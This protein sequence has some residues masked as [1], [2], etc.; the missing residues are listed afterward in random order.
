[1]IIEFLIVLLIG[2]VAGTF[3]GL[4]PGIHVNLIAVF[5]LSMSSVFLEYVS[6][7]ALVVFITAMAITHSFLDF[8]PSIFLGAPDEDSFLAVLPGHELLKEGKGY[9]AVILTLYGSFIALFIILIFVPIFV[10]VLPI[11]QGS[12]A[13]VLPF[14]LIFISFF[15]I[16]REE[17]F[18]ISLIVFIFAGFLGLVTFNLPIK[19]PLLP[20]LTGLFGASALIVS[21][22]SGSSKLTEQKIESIRKIRISKRQVFKN[23][24][25][26]A[27]AAP[28]CSFLPGIG[29]GHAAVIGSE[30]VEQDKRGFLFLVGAINTI[31][32]ALSF[33][34][35][36]SIGRTRSGAA[37][38]I[39]EILGLVRVSDLII[40]IITIVFSGII[41]FFIGVGIARLAAKYIHKINYKILSF[42][43]LGVLL[44]INLIFSN[45][46]GIVVLMTATCLGIFTILSGTRRINLMGSLLIPTII[47]YLTI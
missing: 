5:L 26:A 38:A 11:I 1:M 23:S 16:F 29:A 42:I 35:L 2:I 25:A 24:V 33:I 19:E 18:L 36:Y 46:F 15:L 14:I 47:F 3:T 4:I 6:P 32:I 17:E 40:I 30:I 37:V 8:I 28:L 31:V 41:A 43:T 9:E 44:T 22:K 7:I 10:F 12:I 34:A 27:I 13:N 45:F 39:K 21:V 20:L